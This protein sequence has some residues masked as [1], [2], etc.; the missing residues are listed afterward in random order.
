M[1]NIEK[2]DKYG[3][4][5]YS[6]L[7]TLDAFVI[8]EVSTYIK[9]LNIRKGDTILDLGGNIGAFATLAIS[10]GAKVISI[11]PELENF[12]MLKAN[13]ALNNMKATTIQKACLGLKT[14]KVIDFYINT[15]RNKGAHSMLV[16]R[17]RDKI[18]VETIN[19]NDLILK[20]KPNKIKCDVEG[21]ELDILLGLNDWK[22]I[23][24]VVI[25]Y[26]HNI[27]RNVKDFHVLI[28]L[29]KKHFKLVK[30]KT[31][32]DNNKSWTSYI[33]ASKYFF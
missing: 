21:A 24:T 16:K 15:K 29:I 17:G 20:Y 4:K 6:R 11:E 25:E 8:G 5:F 27:L 7:D 23:E 32:D 2:I 31:R 10:K 14:D 18:S 33:I 12:E 1:K 30:Y 28:D 9:K 19:I 22:N 13:L 3:L 26:H